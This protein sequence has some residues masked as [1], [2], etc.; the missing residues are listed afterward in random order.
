METSGSDTDIPRGVDKADSARG[1]MSCLIPLLVLAILEILLVVV[2]V[3]YWAYDRI[4]GI[5]N[6][7]L[8]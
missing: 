4:V 5:D 6:V 1:C 8:G 3:L 7:K 2:M